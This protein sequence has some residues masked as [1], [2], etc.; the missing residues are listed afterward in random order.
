MRKIFF[1]IAIIFAF[2][3]LFYFAF[4]KSSKP[5]N[6]PA[7]ETSE[8]A[9]NDAQGV[10]NPASVYC[11]DNGG[12]VEIITESDGSQFGLC[13]FSDYSCEEWTYYNG[14]CDIEKDAELILNT[15]KA[16]GLDLTDM[17]VVI[18][19]HL[20]ENI[21]GAVVP[22][23]ALAGGGYVFAVKKD[24]KVEIVADG[25]GAITCSM[26]ENFP[27]FSTYLIP[28]CYDEASEVLVAR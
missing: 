19:K 18:K 20:G 27:D 7:N 21:Q 25:N 3:A 12:E 14:E 15:L 5:S 10:A 17:K 22:V 6:Q 1:V 8:L 16:K 24:G 28:E 4:Y 23:S 9:S 13:N 11:Q 2:S 26:L